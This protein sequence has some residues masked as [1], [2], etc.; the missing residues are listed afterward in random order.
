MKID[1]N[2]T[3]KQ[4]RELLGLARDI[5]KKL[6]GFFSLNQAAFKDERAALL[7][8]YIQRYEDRMQQTLAKTLSS[9]PEEVLDTYFQFEPDDLSI[10]LDMEGLDFQ[11]DAD[12]DDLIEKVIHF[13]EVLQKFY[14]HAAQMSHSEPV[15]RIFENLKDLEENK[16]NDE[17]RAALS[18]QDL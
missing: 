5:Y 18:L 11:S 17:I 14:S 13:D 2:Q 7:A 4:T 8:D 1:N 12:T 9:L 10:I 3:Y 15:T 16:R 6:T